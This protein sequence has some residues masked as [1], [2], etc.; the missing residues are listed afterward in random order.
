MIK[1]GQKYKNSVGQ[2]IEIVSIATNDIVEYVV[3]S[4]SFKRQ[5]CL[6]SV[7]KWVNGGTWVLQPITID[8]K[9]TNQGLITGMSSYQ[10]RINRRANEMRTH[11]VTIACI[12]EWKQYTGIVEMYKYCT[13]CDRKE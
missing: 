5:A 11:N 9:T 6:N 8:F 12:H 13:K 1:V 3:K 7:E 4:G 10:E 2:I